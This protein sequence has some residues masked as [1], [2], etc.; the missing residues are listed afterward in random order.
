[1]PGITVGDMLAQS[2]D[3]L[4]E[5]VLISPS[6]G[7]GIP[8]ADLKDRFGQH[9]SLG[10]QLGYL[11]KKGG[12]FSINYNLIFGSRVKEDVLSNLRTIEGGIIGRDMQFAS[13]FLRERGHQLYINAGRFLRFRK[14]TAASG[15]LLA[16]GTG[17]LKH[18]IRIVDDF[19]SVTQLQDPYIK[20]YDRL[21]SGLSL[22]QNIS[23]LHLSKDKLV[24]FFIN[25][26]FTEG[27]I[28]DRRGI[29]YNRSPLLLERKDILMTI[30]VGWVLPIYFKKE[31]RYY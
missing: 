11:N 23:Y 24:N 28:R 16:A 7:L 9:F 25:L 1:M 21:S 22:H 8:L 18:K 20:G 2:T 12:Y 29:N 30:Q 6:Y 31:I 14:G 3:S 13:V 15:I 5:S 27:F 26:Q 10:G 17:F 4:G 19:D